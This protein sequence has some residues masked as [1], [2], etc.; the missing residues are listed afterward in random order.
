MTAE[1][2]VVVLDVD[3]IEDASMNG[4]STIAIGV[5]VVVVA[6]AARMSR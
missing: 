6:L 3:M 5:Q 4:V 2:A 1:V